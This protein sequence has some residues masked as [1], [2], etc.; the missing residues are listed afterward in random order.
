MT[1]PHLCLSRAV[2]ISCFSAA[3]SSLGGCR[4]RCCC[5]PRPFLSLEGSTWS[6]LPPRAPSPPGGPPAPQDPLCRCCCGCQCLLRCCG[7]PGCVGEGG[8]STWG[9]VTALLLASGGVCSMAGW[10]RGVGRAL[11]GER[12]GGGTVCDS[13]RGELPPDSRGG[14]AAVK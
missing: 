11:A 2:E 7:L 10:L 8:G 5:W 6:P 13:Y 3:E 1:A 14:E 12:G 4:C 9:L